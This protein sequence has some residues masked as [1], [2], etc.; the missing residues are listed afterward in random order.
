M[1]ER[2]VS[3]PTE[4]RDPRRVNQALQIV[5]ARMVQSNTDVPTVDNIILVTQAEYNALSPP[6]A[7]TIYFTSDTLAIYLG[8]V[9]YV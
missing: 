8:S 6:D 7:T 1:A 5:I 3:I 9:Q 4:T 2:I